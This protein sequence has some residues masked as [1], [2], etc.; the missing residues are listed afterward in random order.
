MKKQI[1]NRKSAA[2]KRKIYSL[3]LLAALCGMAFVACKKDDPLAGKDYNTI[4]TVKSNDG[5][6]HYNPSNGGVEWD[7]DDEISVARGNVVAENPFELVSL[8]NGVAKFGGNISATEGAYYAVYP[9]QDIAIN[10]GVVTCEVIKTRQILTENTFGKGNNTSVGCGSSTT[11]EFKNLGGL[12]KIAVRGTFPLKSIKISCSGTPLSGRG[13]VDLLSM[14]QNPTIEWASEGTFDYVEAVAP[15]TN[16]VSVEGGKWFYV[17]LPPCTMNRYTVTLAGTHGEN[18][19]KE[20]TTP[21]TIS[22]S[23]VVLLGAFA[24]DDVATIPESNQICYTATSKLDFSSDEWWGF[25]VTNHRYAPETGKGCVTFSETI[26]SIPNNAFYNWFT[27]QGNN[28][29]TSIT[30]PASVTSIGMHAFHGCSNL[31]SV[32]MPGV[33]TINTHAFSECSR[34]TSVSMP[35]VQNIGQS[36]FDQCDIRIVELPAIQSIDDFAFSDNYNLQS[37]DLGSSIGSLGS[38]AFVN[39]RRSISV[40]KCRATSCPSYDAGR[41]PF[42]MSLTND[43]VLHVPHNCSAAYS[44]WSDWFEG[45]IVDDLPLPSNK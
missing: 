37:V 1:K 33:Q 8:E 4:I 13:S 2:M 40:V 6:T 44:G 24:A 18:L 26:T 38:S 17:V 45:R 5:K 12:A 27:W 10:N 16:G 9:A 21:V 11:M 23:S 36:A 43:V 14:G 28:S 7:S 30:L 32:S 25:T 3:A 20:Y 39:H 35:E 41:L 22:R 42:D 31:A 19:V 34:L 15:E 29:I